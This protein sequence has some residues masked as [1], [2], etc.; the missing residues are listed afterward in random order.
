VASSET[1][2]NIKAI[3]NVIVPRNKQ[4]GGMV[5]TVVAAFLFLVSLTS[6]HPDSTPE[7]TKATLR[8]RVE[9]FYSLLQL[10]RWDPAEAYVV[11]SSREAYRNESKNPFLG[12]Q[13]D[14]IKLDP[15][16]KSAAVVVQ[17]QFIAGFSPTPVSLSRTSRWKLVDGAWYIEIPPG[18]PRGDNSLALFQPGPK[19]SAPPPEEL[20]F[21]GHRFGLGKMQPGEKKVARF[22]FANV[23]DHVVRISEVLTG[24][25]CLQV[26]LEKKEYTPGESGEVVVEFDSTGYENEYTQTLVVRTDPGNIPVYLTVNAFVIRRVPAEANREKDR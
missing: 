1:H 12:F 20:E 17:I 8:A 10:G 7:E 15:D 22:P 5:P 11:E 14:S 2:T 9:E 23:T 4:L 6:A 13:V 19:T 16:G 21:K 18:Q 26:R 24:C 3:M 25:D